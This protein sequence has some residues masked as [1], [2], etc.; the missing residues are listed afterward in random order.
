VLIAGAGPAGYTSAIY[1]ARAGLKTTLLTG[2]LP[3]GQLLNTAHIENYPGYF[4]RPAPELMRTMHQQCLALPV[5]IL[6]CL[7]NKITKES[8]GFN[9]TDSAGCKHLVD[10]VIIATGA[11]PKYLGVPGEARLLGSGVSTCATCDGHFYRDQ[12]VVVIGGGN[13]AVE[14]AIYLC[15]IARKV[16]LVHRRDSLR[17]EHTLQQAL[18][19]RQN[20]E[21]HWNTTVLSF[22]GA[23]VLDKVVLSNN[24]VLQVGG[25]FVAI[26]HTPNTDWC[27]DAIKLDP[28]GYIQ[29]YDLEGRVSISPQPYTSVQGI[30]AAGDVSDSRYRQAITAA[31]QGCVAAIEV[32]KWLH[33]RPH[34]R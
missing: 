4:D 13:T 33:D 28:A 1:S 22:E 11:N 2:P 17:A 12:D 19:T 25:A 23:E 32:Q 8:N 10:A 30:F 34:S 18:L 15:T 16:H 26:G 21:F 29:T 31:G 27:K 20:I 9:I 3:G 5:N 7:A 14:E 24:T 6:L